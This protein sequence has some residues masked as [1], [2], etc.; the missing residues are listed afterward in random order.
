MSITVSRRSE[1]QQHSSSARQL[2]RCKSQSSESNKRQQV[3][4]ETYS[5]FSS[6]QSNDH[7]TAGPLSYS[8]PPS[9][10]TSPEPR[11]GA[12]RP[13]LQHPHAE[14]IRGHQQ[15][16]SSSAHIQPGAGGHK[17]MA[18]EIQMAPIPAVPPPYSK[19]G[20]SAHHFPQHELRRP[21]QANTPEA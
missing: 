20:S 7:R 14:S 19:R 6:Q 3:H 21:P 17:H 10:L 15:S 4:G 9:Q 1:A 2:P 11:T 5:I 12:G 16:P 8:P 13:D 18:Y